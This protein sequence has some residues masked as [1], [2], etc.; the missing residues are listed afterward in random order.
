M[1]LLLA[2]QTLVRRFVQVVRRGR[3]LAGLD[4]LR[5]RR[6]GEEAVF[7]IVDEFAFL[8]FLHVFNQGRKCSCT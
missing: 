2:F 4:A 8:T 3:A 5:R 7:R 1:N 6:A